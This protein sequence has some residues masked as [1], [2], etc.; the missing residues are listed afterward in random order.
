MKKIAIEEHIS[1]PEFMALRYTTPR[2]KARPF[3]LDPAEIERLNPLICDGG[4]LRLSVMDACEVDRCILMSGSV[5]FDYIDDP[6]EAA[7]QTRRFNNYLAD[8]VMA[9][10]PK[11][12]QAFATLP[13]QT[14]QGAAEELRRCMALPGFVG[15][16][17]S[18][19]PLP[20]RFLDEAEYEPLWQAAEETGAYLY[21]HPMETP[22]DA[23][24]LYRDYTCMN[25]STWSWGT[26]TAA[27]VLR[28]VFSGVF[29]RHAGARLI[30][31]HMGEM[32]PFVLERLDR[33]WQVSP[34][35]SRNQL[36]PSEYFHRNIY[37]SVSGNL[38][39]PALKCAIAAMGAE[40]ILFAVD[41]PFE[42]MERFSQFIE[43]ADITQE[44]RELICWKNA[45]RLFPL[46]D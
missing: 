4:E 15:A 29:D 33:R 31:G 39:V 36:A 7:E 45:E 6:A 16:V 38:S 18:G 19:S 1:K 40:R 5:G 26:D 35:D 17:V 28:L 34:M 11:R 24:A 37:I 12:F 30:M 41:Y 21:I 13:M 3:P 8:E 23:K 9:D 32:L 44:E 20:G 22:D 46:L 2:G 25:G 42:S 27:F 43:E 10:H 14:G